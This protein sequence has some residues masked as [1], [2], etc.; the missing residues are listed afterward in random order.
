MAFKYNPTYAA[1]KLVHAAV[2]KQFLGSNQ[3]QKNKFKF[4]KFRFH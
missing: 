2:S 4:N 3:S 1:T